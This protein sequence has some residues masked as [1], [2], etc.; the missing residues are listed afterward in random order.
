MSESDVAPMNEEETAAVIPEAP[1]SPP[2]EKIAVLDHEG[3]LVG[4]VERVSGEGDLVLSENHPPAD[5]TFMF[6]AGRFITV[7]TLVAVLDAQARLVGTITKR[8]PDLAPGEIALPAAFDLPTNG[9][10]KW[11]PDH[12]AFLPLGHGFPKVASKPAITEAAVLYQLAKRFAPELPQDV[13][14]WVGWYEKNLKARDDELALAR[15]MRR[16]R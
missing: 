11:V 10:Y 16:G 4:I 9:T 12:K 2:T 15:R 7:D 5:G 8:R 13:A 1:P 3:I 6:Q 14:D